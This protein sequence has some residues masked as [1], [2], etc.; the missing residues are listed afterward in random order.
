MRYRVPPV[1]LW[2]VREFLSWVVMHQLY[3]PENFRQKG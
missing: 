1:N 2:N 3:D